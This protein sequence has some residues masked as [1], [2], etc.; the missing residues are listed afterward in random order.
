MFVIF[1]FVFALWLWGHRHDYLFRYVDRRL[2]LVPTRVYGHCILLE[3]SSIKKV[4]GRYSMA[5]NPCDW[6]VLIKRLFDIGSFACSKILVIVVFVFLFFC[7][8]VFLFF[9]FF[10]FLCV[11][12]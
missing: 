7:F 12:V 9:C 6:L 4:S 3:S 10:V 11:K 2:G 5:F 8:F 1:L